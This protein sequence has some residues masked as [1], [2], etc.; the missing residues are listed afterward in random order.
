[1]PR[2]CVWAPG[3]GSPPFLETDMEIWVKT[4]S[5]QGRKGLGSGWALLVPISLGDPSTNLA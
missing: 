5:G 3:N 2:Q 1:M 4:T